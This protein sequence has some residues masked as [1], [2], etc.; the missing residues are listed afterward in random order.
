MKFSIKTQRGRAYEDTIDYV[1]VHNQDGEV[2]ILK[3]HIPIVLSVKKG[4][5]KL[6]KGDDQQFVVLEQA[7][8]EFE[9]NVLSVLSFEAQIGKTFEEA[10]LIYEKEKKER[11]DLSKKENIDYSKLQKD[12][13]DAI[14]KSKAGQV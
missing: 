4:H 12:L 2:A 1:V 14:K 8:V 7:I 3:D 5:I 9:Q 6:V 13:M 10:K 11:L